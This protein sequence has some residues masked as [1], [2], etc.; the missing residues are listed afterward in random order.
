MRGAQRRVPPVHHCVRITPARAGN[1][2]SPAHSP[3]PPLCHAGSPPRLRGVWASKQLSSE[4]VRITPACTGNMAPASLARATRWDHPRMCMVRCFGTYASSSFTGSPPR[5]RRARALQSPVTAVQWITPRSREP[6]ARRLHPRSRRGYRGTVCYDWCHPACTGT[7][8]VVADVLCILGSPPRLRGAF[9]PGHAAADHR[10]ITPAHTGSTARQSLE[11]PGPTDHPRVC[12]EDSQ[13]GRPTVSVIGPPP[14]VRGARDQR[15][16]PVSTG[17]HMP[18]DHPRV[19][20]E[21]ISGDAF[22]IAS[23]GSPPRVRGTCMD[24]LILERGRTDH[25]RVCRERSQ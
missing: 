9:R 18:V 19:C 17:N 15:P 25:P 8:A 21:H 1:T 7:R 14:P 2:H 20:R 13:I 6:Q 11:P 5:V 10:R 4:R 24:L 3:P 16:E 12:G 22:R 23:L